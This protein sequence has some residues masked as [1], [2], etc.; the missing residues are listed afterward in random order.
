M[1]YLTINMISNFAMQIQLKYL[2]E[3]MQAFSK[4]LEK[5]M[6]ELAASQNDGPI[7][8]NFCKVAFQC[9]SCSINDA[10]S[11]LSMLIIYLTKLFT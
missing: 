11:F 7:S 5:V 4:G 8:E 9:Y 6:Q 1:N 10:I 2:A 3:E